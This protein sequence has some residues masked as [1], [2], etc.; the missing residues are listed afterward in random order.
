MLRTCRLAGWFRCPRWKMTST[1]WMPS[2]AAGSAGVAGRCSGWAIRSLCRCARWTWR[3]AGSISSWRRRVRA[4]L[5]KDVGLQLRSLR[6]SRRARRGANQDVPNRLRVV[7]LR[8]RHRLQRRRPLPAVM[9]PLPGR[10]RGPIRDGPNSQPG[11]TRHRSSAGSSGFGLPWCSRRRRSGRCR[12][13]S[14]RK[15]PVR[16]GRPCRRERIGRIMQ[17]PVEGGLPGAPRL[18]PPEHRFR[19]PRVRLRGL[20]QSGLPVVERSVVAIAGPAERAVVTS[21][22]RAVARRRGRQR[23]LRPD[24]RSPVPRRNPEPLFRCGR[25]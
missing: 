20:L 12:V 10:R 9:R 2:G 21:A 24:L 7:R 3:R 15:D 19:S 23:R 17:V 22:V 1:C 11:P 13:R 25:S 16:A 5:P 8:P 6:R 4:R 18:R 14:K